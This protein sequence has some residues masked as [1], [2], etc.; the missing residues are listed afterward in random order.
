M[1]QNPISLTPVSTNSSINPTSPAPLRE[2]N[3]MNAVYSEESN[4]LSI[5]CT[6][7]LPNGVNVETD[8]SVKQ[9]YTSGT[10]T[11]MTFIID[12]NTNSS[13]CVN[14]QVFTFNALSSNSAGEIDLAAIE[15]VAFIAV[16]KTPVTSRGTRAKVT[17]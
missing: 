12:L 5:T 15:D 9:Y 16:N 11:L 3:G 1:S 8:V 2:V 10:N 6:V 4:V 14:S 17:A 7:W 13:T